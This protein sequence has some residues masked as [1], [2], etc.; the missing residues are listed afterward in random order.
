VSLYLSR[1]I[2]A[3]S[4]FI[5]AAVCVHAEVR[6]PAIIGDNMVLQQGTKVRIW[7]NANAGENV[8][9]TFAGKTLNTVAGIDGRWQIMLGPLEPVGPSEDRRRF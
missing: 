5:P 1:L 9:V 2:L 6:L 3:L 4:V 8:S 7:G